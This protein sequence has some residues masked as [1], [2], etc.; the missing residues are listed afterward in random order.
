MKPSRV[1]LDYV[2]ALHRP[3]WLGLLLLVIALGIAADLFLRFRATQQEKARVDA[4]QGL[5]VGERPAPKAVAPERL[6]DQVRAA[7][8]AVRQLTLPWAALI[9]TLENTATPDVAVLQVQPEA[10]QQL[11][12]ITAEAR[13]H[14]A[15][16]E[17]V[18]KLVAAE[19]LNNVHWL[20]HQVQNDDPQRPLQFSVQ[21]NFR[22]TR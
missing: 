22:A 18:R 19:T 7:E 10:Q 21:A 1:E 9:A 14:K 15:M 6:D 5:V 12:R 11:L 2:R 8:A 3:R 16:L 4:I 20:N 13:H 17:Y